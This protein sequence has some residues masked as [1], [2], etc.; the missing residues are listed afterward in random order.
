M[1]VTCPTCDTRFV[2]DDAALGGNAGRRVRCASC[3]HLW[4]YS[5]EST[6]IH[7]A[8]AEVTGS[9]T[10]P[11]PTPVLL[12]PAEPLRGETRLE[13]RVDP[14]LDTPRERDPEPT[15][16]SA[17]PAALVRP[18]VEVEMPAA[19]RSRRRR[20]AGL[21]LTILAIAVIAIVVLSHNRILALRPQIEALY[22]RLGSTQPS[23][24]GLEVKVTP[25]RTTDSL[26]I[27]G[28][29]VN[30]NSEARRLPRLRVSLRDTSNDSLDSRVIDP[31]VPELAPGASA[32]FNTVFQHPSTTATGVAVTFATD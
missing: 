29:I 27:D 6:A 18:S 3:G 10:T 12:S 32:H 1:I 11:S 14:R 23:T 7:A 28:D 30:N 16:R 22:A 15:P 26:V 17:G 25:T 2:V 5:P 9:D 24:A 8:V 31:P 19:A 4:H 13:S 20:V 21:L